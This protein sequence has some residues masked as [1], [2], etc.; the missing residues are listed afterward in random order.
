MS[1]SL[2]EI[3]G[4]ED[5]SEVCRGVYSQLIAQYG[6]TFDPEN[7]PVE[8]C[9]VLFVWHA[10]RLIGNGGFNGFFKVNFPADPQYVHLREAFDA[11]SCEPA[12]SVL[13]RVFDIFPNC[14]P[15]ADASERFR[16][17]VRANH[18]VQ[19]AFNRD[20]AKIQP[21]LVAALATYI[22]EHAKAFADLSPTSGSESN[23]APDA[24]TTEPGADLPKWAQVAFYA[25]CA[26]QLLPLWED[27]WPA[28][29]M[30]Y[31]DV[32]EQTIKLA[33]SSA[34]HAKPAGDLK[35][36]AAHVARIPSAAIAASEGRDTPD[37]HPEHPARAALIAATAGSTL[38]L[39]NGEGD[40]SPYACAK[41]V[42]EDA[43]LDDLL[44]DIHED[45]ERIASLAQEYEW[46]DRTPVPPEVFDQNFKP[47][48]KSWWKRS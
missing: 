29:P 40:I 17:F 41:A 10:S 24:E 6:K 48:R 19:G 43:G 18:A 26:R 15:P 42:T 4:A 1:K 30:E 2:A 11:V 28:A 23:D 12:A 14:T 8:F 22:R 21:A 34:A 32:I 31:R 20:F 35:A 3:L 46:D 16:S 27:A 38:D 33:E 13:G 5:D 45:F 9:T 25:R 7:L 47:S 44:A 36:A 37:H 39:I